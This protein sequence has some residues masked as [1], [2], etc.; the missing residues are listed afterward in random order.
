MNK[1]LVTTCLIAIV[2]LQKEVLARE[3]AAVVRLGGLLQIKPGVDGLF[4][5]GGEYEFGFEGPIAM[6]S[7]AKLG[8]GKDV[9]R[10]DD[11]VGLSVTIPISKNLNIVPRGD[12]F[13]SIL[14]P[15]ESLS[16]I[17]L[18]VGGD[19]GPGITYSVSK[20]FG[21]G[22]DLMA[23]MGKIWG[24]TSEAKVVKSFYAALVGSFLLR[25]SY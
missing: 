13:V 4:T 10:E 1:I 22:F 15:Y 3:D 14:L 7:G 6:V 21:I 11:Y 9:F 18:T 16:S 17:F 19:F 20:S 5:I 2:L 8:F 23:E 12:F 24:I 25:F